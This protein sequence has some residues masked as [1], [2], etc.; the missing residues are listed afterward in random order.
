[1]AV[2]LCLE[3]FDLWRKYLKRMLALLLFIKCLT[4]AVGAAGTYQAYFW[5]CAHSNSDF[6]LPYLLAVFFSVCWGS[7]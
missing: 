3:G 5:L 4:L 7:F 6:N 1:M 2:H